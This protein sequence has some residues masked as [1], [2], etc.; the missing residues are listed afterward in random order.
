MNQG[1]RKSDLWGSAPTRKGEGVEEARWG[2][3]C[4]LSRIPWRASKHGPYLRVSPTWRQRIWGLVIWQQSPLPLITGQGRHK[5][6]RAFGLSSLA[7]EGQSSE[8][9]RASVSSKACWSWALRAG[10]KAW[11]DLGRVYLVSII[12]I[13]KVP[14]LHGVRLKWYKACKH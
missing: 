4:Q 2:R 8:G 10:K 6:P 12:G 14:P 7:G 13:V 5:T 11:K 3:K 9:C 1:F